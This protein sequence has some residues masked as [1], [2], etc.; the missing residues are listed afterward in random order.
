[1]PIT[2]NTSWQIDGGAWAPACPDCHR[3]ATPQGSFGKCSD[4]DWAVCYRDIEGVLSRI[5]PPP[6]PDDQWPY[7]AKRL[8]S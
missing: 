2:H 3:R 8:L 6:A 5:G 4:P 7:W 1:M